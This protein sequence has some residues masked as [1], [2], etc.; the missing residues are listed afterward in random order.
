M[1]ESPKSSA[2]SLAEL[3]KLSKALHPPTPKVTT[4]SPTPQTAPPGGGLQKIDAATIVPP[5]INRG[6]LEQIEDAAGGRDAIISSLSLATLDKKQQFFLDLLCDPK[7][8]KDNISTIARDAGLTPLQI[9]DL[10][11]SSAFASA[12]A[13][14]SAHL[15]T[16]LPEIVQDIA[17]KSVDATV[18]CPT[19]LG[20]GYLSGATCLNCDG[21]GQVFRAS[22]LDRQK[23][24]LEAT[25]VVK[26]GPGVNVQVNQQVGIMQ[27]G[28]FFSK[29]VKNSDEAAYDVSVSEVKSSDDQS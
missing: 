17:A 3:E 20:S 6:A 25:G 14:A 10:F 13:I 26:K 16:A 28:A 21:R 11:R 23:L 4:T 29:W 12:H 27:P 9:L 18:A 2:I 1:S 15:S 7:R 22:D 24:V 5:K 19:C 8:G